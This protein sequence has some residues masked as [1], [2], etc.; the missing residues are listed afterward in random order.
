MCLKKYRSSIINRILEDDFKGHIHTSKYAKL[1]KCSNDTALR[2][3]QD[4]MAR[5][6][7]VQN[8]GRG[9]TT[10]YRLPERIPAAINAQ[11][12]T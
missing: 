1:I 11:K 10:S 2:D 3:I 5:G 12:T 9:R 4:L 8:P 6:I 7:L